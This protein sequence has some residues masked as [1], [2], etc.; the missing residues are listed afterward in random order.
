MNTQKV[1]KVGVQ[2]TRKLEWF[3]PHQLEGREP[4]IFTVLITED[5]TYTQSGAYCVIDYQRPRYRGPRRFAR[6]V[7]K[8]GFFVR[9]PHIREVLGEGYNV[10]NS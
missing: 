9:V 7:E 2:G 1:I 5:G 8:R 3:E 6:P 4:A 10:Q